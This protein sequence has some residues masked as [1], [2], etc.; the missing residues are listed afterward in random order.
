M[1]DSYIERKIVFNPEYRLR[2]DID[3]VIL[4]SSNKNRSFF[5]FIHPMYAVLFSIFK[6]NKTL[7]E[8]LLEINKLF[9]V[10]EDKAM[11]VIS[12]FIENKKE[13]TTEYDG[14]YFSF[15]KKIL[16]YHDD[17]FVREDINCNQ[18]I[19]G[20][21]YNFKRIRFSIPN[22]ILLIVNLSCV[23]DCIYCYANREKK[24]TPLPTDRILQI[25]DEAKSMQIENFDISGGELFLHKDWNIILKSLLINGFSPYISTKIPLTKTM[26]DTLYDVGM[27]E[28]QIS[29][30]SL[31]P[32]IQI[33]NLNVNSSYI[34]KMK[35]SLQYIDS[36]GIKMIIKGT[37]T[38]YTL[39][40][41]NIG[42]VIRFLKTLKHVKRYMISLIGVTLY[43]PVNEYHTIKP[44]MEQ[45]SEIIKYINEERKKNYFEIVFDNQN[46]N[47]SD[48][49]NY[50]EFKERSLCTGNVD[51]FVILPDGNVTIC[52]E[53]YWNEHFIIG[54]L[55]E[56][57]ICDV[58]NSEK[59]VNLWNL[60]QN[61]FLDSNP[62]SSCQDFDNCRKGKGVCWKMVVKGYSWDNYLY[63]DPRCPKA[64]EL[65]YDI[66]F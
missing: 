61:D 58:W 24:Y 22:S 5:R 11:D 49:C 59:A 50:T 51:G 31:N 35:N 43:K 34:D 42:E 56:S 10:S 25:I 40:P 30:D 13:V 60:Q 47:K 12:V 27:K 66:C 57:S 29:L 37:H 44:E 48:I 41:E 55:A 4:M 52:E 21:P 32:E 26:V 1:Q 39:T 46:I 28:I 54:N 8:Y 63:P 19:L 9:D 65:K 62:C 7:P 15:P 23:T 2:A 33:N 36:K 3:R 14:Q 16:V 18:Y 53:L 45:T 17:H 64:P 6:G 20:L 38:R